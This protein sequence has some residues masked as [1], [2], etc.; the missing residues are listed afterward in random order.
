MIGKTHEICQDYSVAGWRKSH[1]QRRNSPVTAGEPYVI[2]S[3]GCSSSPDTDIGARL[4]VKAA[5]RLIC[6][7]RRLPAGDVYKIH[8][9]AA[10]L[11]LAQAKLM[12][13]K[14]QSVD[15]TLLTI[16]LCAGEFIVACYGDG[17]IALKSRT[18][19]L[20]VY[21]ISF[22]A[23]YPRYPGYAHQPERLRLFENNSGHIK[24]VT[25]YRMLP[26]EE[27]VVWQDSYT[28]EIKAETFTGQTEDYQFAAVLTDGIHSFAG[29][30]QTETTKK[31]API[32]IGDVL[33]EL[34]AFKNIHGAFVQRRLKRFLSDC[35]QRDW[36]HHDDLAVGAVYFGA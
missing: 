19:Q 1:A 30:R 25:H 16:H 12:R 33:K 17:V 8:E 24:E 35:Q 15:A 10:H 36:Q 32:H 14:P 23:G 34:L 27:N 9:K 31:V 21:S 6:V 20:D 29:A 7:P 4:L 11:A 2:V 22:S 28:S 3:D 5:E 18:G 26:E 13:L